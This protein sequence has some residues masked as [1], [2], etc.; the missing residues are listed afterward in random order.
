LL[1]V[2]QRLVFLRLLGQRECGPGSPD[3][4]DS[5][6]GLRAEE[7]TLGLD[8]GPLFVAGGPSEYRGIGH[9]FRLTFP[10]EVNTP[11]G[12]GRASGRRLRREQLELESV[13][14]SPSRV[15]PLCRWTTPG[16]QARACTLLTKKPPALPRI[17]FLEYFC[18]AEGN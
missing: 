7:A 16:G 9:P 3:S 10:A 13:C 12:R 1:N 2:L 17:I 11:R 6:R 8:A 14:R 5:G 4:W 18:F 15:W